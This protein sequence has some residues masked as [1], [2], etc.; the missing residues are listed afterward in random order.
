MTP[1][2]RVPRNEPSVILDYLEVGAGGII[3]PNVVSPARAEATVRA[4]KYPPRGARGG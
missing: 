1:L 3:V 2:V 4:I